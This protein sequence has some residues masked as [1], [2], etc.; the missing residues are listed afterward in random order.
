MRKLRVMDFHAV[1]VH[2]NTLRDFSIKKQTHLKRLYKF[3]WV[4]CKSL[5]TG[6]SK[7]KYP[8]TKAQA[9]HVAKRKES[10]QGRH[11]SSNG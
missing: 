2:H 4:C 9:Q 1:G 8:P 7:I 11:V 6:L 3:Y 5:P 10:M